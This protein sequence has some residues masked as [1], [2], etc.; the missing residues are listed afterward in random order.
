MRLPLLLGLVAAAGQAAADQEAVAHHFPDDP[1]FGHQW[2]LSNTGQGGRVAGAD[3]GATE[4]WAYTRGSPDIVIAVLD[5]GVQLDHP[6]LAPNLAGAGLDFT[7]HPPGGD[8]GPRASRDRHGTSVAGI[9][10]ARGDNGIGISGMCP[11]CTILP[12]RI[13]KAPTAGTA[14]AIRYAVEQGASI[15]VNSWGYAHEE[16][17]AATADAAVRDAIEFAAH[18]GRDGRGALIVFAVTNEPVDNCGGPRAD[19]ASLDS[20]LAVGVADHNDRVGGSGFG[21]CVD[22]VAPSKPRDRTTIG[23]TTTDRTGLDG[24]SPGDYDARFGGTS[25]AAP[26]VAGIAGLLLSMNTELSRT[27]LQR[28]LEH[29]AEK[30]DA[31][32]AEYDAAGFS[33]RAGHGRVSAAR[34]LVPTVTISVQPSRVRAGEPFSVSVRASAPFGLA[35]VSWFGVDTGLEDFDR[36]RVRAAA[37]QAIHSV[38]WNGIVIDR[39]GTYTLGAD[40]V[41][42]RHPGAEGDRYPHRASDAAGAATAEITV[43]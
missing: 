34:A 1:L 27:D 7:V 5:D 29:T 35:S 22:V 28:I 12:L 24:H 23:V 33:R 31:D 14:A 39:M 10:A 6:D 19:I 41:D 32:F 15:I 3:V 2:P 13:D 4:A 38:T 26:L 9:A 11:R 8:G 20:V 18:H 40:A 16:S 17:A 43:R 36:P 30:V 42:A 21:D 37:G 25:A